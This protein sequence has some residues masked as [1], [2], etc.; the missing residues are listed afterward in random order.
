MKLAAISIIPALTGSLVY[1]GLMG[2]FGFKLDI[3]NIVLLAIVLG[4]SNDDVIMFMV[5][6]QQRIKGSTVNSA[7]SKTKKETGLAILQ[8]TAII[9]IGISVLFFSSFTN[10]YK[11]II[12]CI[13]SLTFS[14]FVT[15]R[16]IP[17][18]LTLIYKNKKMEIG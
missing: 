10:F 8:T 6:F 18:I 5:A 7:I 4:V 13:L 12:L 3:E 1:F 17:I 9:I 11:S 15:I 14:T 2:W 16:I